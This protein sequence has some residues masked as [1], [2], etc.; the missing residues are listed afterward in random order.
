M[1]KAAS[2][3]QVQA[4]AE[5]GWKPVTAQAHQ[6]TAC[7]P[8]VLPSSCQPAVVACPA[9]VGGS[10][11]CM[12]TYSMS[13]LP[14]LPALSI[15]GYPIRQPRRVAKFCQPAAAACPAAV[16]GSKCCMRRCSM[17]PLSVLLALPTCGCPIRQPT[18]GPGV[19]PSSC[20]HAAVDCTAAVGFTCMLNYS[21]H[22]HILSA[23]PE[24]AFLIRPL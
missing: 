1:T 8:A 5:G 10:N 19:L 22:S 7:G 6:A 16:G 21:D 3:Q 4:R 2:W 15:C 24:C 17:S 13:P 12:H 20:Q 9:V 11:C 14:V 18:F 23:L